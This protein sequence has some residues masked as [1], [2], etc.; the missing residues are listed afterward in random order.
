[1]KKTKEQGITLVALVI[2]IIVLLI[3]AGVAL[4]ALFG[5]SSIIDNANYAV[6]EYNKSADADQNVITS[7]EGLFA[8]YMGGDVG[9]DDD[10]DDDDDEVIPPE[11]QE[12][13]GNLVKPSDVINQDLFTYTLSDANHTA[14]VIGINW[15]YFISEDVPSEW[16]ENEYITPFELEDTKESWGNTWL[17]YSVNTQEKANEIASTLRK[18]IVPYEITINDTTYDVTSMDISR[19]VSFSGFIEPSDYGYGTYL[20]AFAAGSD[21]SDKSGATDADTSYLIIPNSVETVNGLDANFIKRDNIIFASNSKVRELP[22]RIFS[23][24]PASTIVLPPTLTSIG[25]EAFALCT[26]L[27]SITI[28]EGVT[29]L[30][31]RNF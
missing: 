4:A 8:K 24:Q 2:T 23:Y 3:L 10:N 9:D 19:F 22:S 5:N 12:Q 27:T 17:T 1:M 13:Y 6:T 7:V 14:T 30:E 15:D 18:L 26:E 28:P 11:L 25:Y 20:P 16:D 31:S 29:T 21:F